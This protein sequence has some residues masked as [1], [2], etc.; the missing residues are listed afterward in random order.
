MARC[1]T[2]LEQAGVDPRRFEAARDAAVREMEAVFEEA[3][4]AD[5]PHSS[6]AF[7]DVLDT[8]AAA[9]ARGAAG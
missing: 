6:T 8:A 7:D 4:A 3:R 2:L 9:S 1:A 5:W